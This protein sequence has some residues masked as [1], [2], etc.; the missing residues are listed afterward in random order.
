MNSVAGG[1][2]QSGRGYLQGVSLYEWHYKSNEAS[3]LWKRILKGKP[4][5]WKWALTRS[6]FLDGREYFY[7]RSSVD[8][9]GNHIVED[10]REAM[11]DIVARE[12]ALYVPCPAKVDNVLLSDHVLVQVVKYPWE[13]V[14]HGYVFFHIWP[15]MDF[16]L[17]EETR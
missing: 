2:T 16:T 11:L 1:T 6:Q 13:E 14:Y 5:P 15:D 10:M 7:K 12:V 17:G 4:L 8:F 9:T 3:V